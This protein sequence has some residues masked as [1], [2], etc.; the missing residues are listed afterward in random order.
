MRPV[1]I[2]PMKPCLHSRGASRPATLIAALALA[3]AASGP[4]ALAQATPKPP[5]RMTYQGFLVDGTGTALGN[6]AP[7]NYDVIF[8][9]YDDQ[10]A[11]TLRWSEQ[12][13]VTIDKGYFSVLLGE[14]AAVG[15]ETHR[16]FRAARERGFGCRRET[17]ALERSPRG[18]RARSGGPG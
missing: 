1:P 10:S 16:R 7:K 2:I 15:I 18:C 5:E 17:G 14:G 9:I 8:R 3:F 6:T 11:G 13:T 4:S 12:Q